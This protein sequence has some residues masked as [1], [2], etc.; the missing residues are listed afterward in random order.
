MNDSDPREEI[1]ALLSGGKLTELLRQAARLHGHYCPGLAFGVM[2]GWAGMKRLGFDNTGMEELL[3]V[4]ECNNCFVD[5]VQMTT[6]CTLGNNALVYKDLGKT[7]V[8][9]M[10]RKTGAAVRVALKPR[11]WDSDEASERDREADEL[12]R[13]IVKERQEDPEASR[14]MK[15]L[16]REKSFETVSKPEEDLFE[17]TR[18]PAV[19]PAYAPIVDSETCKVCGEH[20]MS[21]KKAAEEDDPLCLDCAGADCMAVLGSG[22]CVLKKGAFSS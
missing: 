1:K 4:V 14:R 13:R 9:I 2:A 15:E 11:K 3:A 7:A 5:G 6:G 12:F 22:I 10:S 17:I 19:F 20:F 8:T 21:T 16:F 18:V